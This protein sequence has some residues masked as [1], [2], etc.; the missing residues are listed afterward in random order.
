MN[1]DIFLSLGV[2]LSLTLVLE[3]CYAILY[4]VRGNDLRLVLLANTLTNPVVVLCHQLAGRFWPAGL[5]LVTLVMELCAVGTEGYLYHG[6]SGFKHPWRFSICA[7]L[8]SYMIGYL[9]QGGL[10]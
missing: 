3:S 10:R 6:R 4:R 1:F 5:G 2:S 8:I 7:N 9:L